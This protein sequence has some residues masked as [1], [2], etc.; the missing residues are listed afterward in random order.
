[1]VTIKHIIT[2]QLTKDAMRVV[3][4][5]EARPNIKY[6]GE[7]IL[8][9]RWFFGT[10]WIGLVGEYRL[11]SEVKQYFQVDIPASKAKRWRSFR[12]ILANGVV[13][14][15]KQSYYKGKGKKNSDYQDL[16]EELI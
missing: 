14:N 1:M 3:F 5:I 6:E 8:E 4:E 15:G 10:V 11:P 16:R 9:L 13:F 7:L 2:K 12:W